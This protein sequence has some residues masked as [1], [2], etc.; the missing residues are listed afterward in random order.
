MDLRSTPPQRF[1]NACD[2]AHEAAVAD[3]GA[4][5]F[6]DR[7]Y[8]AGLRVLLVRLAVENMT[9]RDHYVRLENWI[10]A[11][12]CNAFNRQCAHSFEWTRRC[13]LANCAGDDQPPDYMIS[14]R[15]DSTPKLVEVTELLDPGRERRREYRDDDDSSDIALMMPGLLPVANKRRDCFPCWTDRFANPQVPLIEGDSATV[16]LVCPTSRGVSLGR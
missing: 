3:A 11:N 14:A 16:P 9:A 1:S 10:L 2:L 12:F 6:G 5:D 4:S 8:R 13:N 15:P 7:D